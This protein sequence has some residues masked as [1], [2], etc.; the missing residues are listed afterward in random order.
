MISGDD[1][2]F[3][4]RLQFW[5]SE[6]LHLDSFADAGEPAVVQTPALICR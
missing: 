3:D 6:G 2:V 5:T 1:L 4:C